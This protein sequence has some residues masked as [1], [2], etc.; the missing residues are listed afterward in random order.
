MFVM[1][2][3]PIYER[4]IWR[5]MA[6]KW[7]KN[8]I[9][10]LRYLYCFHCAIVHSNLSNFF[11]IGSNKYNFLCVY[12]AS[13]F[14]NECFYASQIA[15]PLTQWNSWNGEPWTFYSTL[16]TMACENILKMWDYQTVPGIIKKDLKKDFLTSNIDHPSLRQV[17]WLEVQSSR[18]LQRAESFDPHSESVSVAGFAK[19][20]LNHIVSFRRFGRYHI[21]WDPRNRQKVTRR[22][23]LGLQAT[24]N[25]SQKMLNKRLVV[26]CFGILGHEAM[27][28]RYYR[29]S[30]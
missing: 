19:Q 7:G 21:S 2:F 9:L 14:N 23:V 10:W 1:T 25:F 12:N 13:T 15:T 30:N 20:I 6:Y 5:W 29:Y 28:G 27:H 22:T 11:L 26:A 18:W 17:Q 16:V 3:L 24:Q 8:R 4:P